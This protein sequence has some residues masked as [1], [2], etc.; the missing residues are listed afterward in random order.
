MSETF[1][2]TI[3]KVGG[4]LGFLMPKYFRDRMKLKEGEECN[5]TVERNGK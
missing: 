1:K 4:S 2:A 5:I 3:I